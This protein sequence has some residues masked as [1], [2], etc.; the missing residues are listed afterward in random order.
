M[1]F[2]ENEEVK[3]LAARLDDLLEKAAKGE[4]GITQFLTPRELHRAGEYLAR[5]GAS[6]VKFGGYSSAERQR[7]YLLPDYMEELSDNEALNDFESKI[8]EYGYSINI[9]L[10]KISG[11]GYRHL[12]HRDFLGS[13][14]GLGIERDVVGDVVLL[15]SEGREAALI[16]DSAIAQFIESELTFVANDKVKISSVSL[17][18]IAL[19]EKRT[20][21]IHDTVAAPRLD[22]VVAALCNLSRDK[23]RTVVTT[24][25]A[26]LDFE[27]EERPDR[28][29]TAP[30]VISVRG[31]GRYRVLSLCDKTKK[32]RYRLE[33]EKYI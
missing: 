26:E 33:A 4:L 23:A 6:Y 12:T 16:C 31:Y 14:L 28:T 10:L 24:G 22:A 5:R 15:D 2:C 32:G 25:L 18:S 21:P 30:A 27:C 13:V 1:N 7:I 20:S 11:S 17:G 9:S 3:T 29:V 19:P 8:S